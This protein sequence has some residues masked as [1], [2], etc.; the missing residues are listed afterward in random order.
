M[1]C[2]CGSTD[3]LSGNCIC[4]FFTHLTFACN[5]LTH[6]TFAFNVCMTTHFQLMLKHESADS[7][8]YAFQ[9]HTV[10][11]VFIADRAASSTELIAAGHSGGQEDRRAPTL[12]ALCGIQYDKSHGSLTQR[13]AGNWKQERPWQTQAH[14]HTRVNALRTT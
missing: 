3:A 1:A 6:L 13:D 9:T 4:H 7:K 11:P 10:T 5:V 8:R 12:Q 14:A 2:P